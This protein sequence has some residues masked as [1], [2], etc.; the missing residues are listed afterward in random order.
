MIHIALEGR[1][2]V[3]SACQY[4]QE[5]DYPP[6]HAVKDPSKRHPD[7]VMIGGGSVIV[8]PLGQVL[9]G[10]LLDGE[11]VLS[12]ELDLDDIVRGKF[13]LDV[14]GHYA[15]NDGK[16]HVLEHSAVTV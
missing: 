6:D 7:N 10:P 1:C 13:D 16:L 9:A 14:V 8:S 15:R 4:S 5:S 11:G 2:F 3:L 12:A